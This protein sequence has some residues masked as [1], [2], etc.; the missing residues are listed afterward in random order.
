MTTEAVEFRNSLRASFATP[1]LTV[2]PPKQ[3]EFSRTN[4]EGRNRTLLGFPRETCRVFHLDELEGF[5]GA[6]SAS[7][8]A[9]GVAFDIRRVEKQLADA[10]H[11][12]TNPAD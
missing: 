1:L 7:G 5:P 8:R 10:V 6:D 12:A 11:L 3:S 2:S 4:T 9:S